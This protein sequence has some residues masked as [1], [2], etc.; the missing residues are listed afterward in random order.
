MNNAFGDTVYDSVLSVELLQNSLGGIH[1]VWDEASRW[2]DNCS[3]VI[4]NSLP[5]KENHSHENSVA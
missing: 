1:Q 3:G 4:S 2:G 5:K